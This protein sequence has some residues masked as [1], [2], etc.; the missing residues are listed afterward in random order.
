[1]IKVLASVG[2][3]FG[4]DVLCMRNYY[5]GMC[6][7]VDNSVE[8]RYYGYK[9]VY[10]DGVKMCLGCWVGEIDTDDLNRVAEKA[11]VEIG[12]GS[13]EIRDNVLWSHF[14][15]GDGAVGE[16]WIV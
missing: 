4:Y 1:M 14:S 3:M 5:S 6:V 16:I 8:C 12:R 15:K 7:F 9:G 2:K 10:V 11:L 13:V